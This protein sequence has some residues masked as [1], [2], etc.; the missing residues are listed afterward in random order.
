MVD[1]LPE[2]SL[3]LDRPA[4]VLSRRVQAPTVPFSSF[5]EDD[6]IAR[7]PAV[8]PTSLRP[9]KRGAPEFG[10]LSVASLIRTAPAGGRGLRWPGHPSI[11]PS[12]LT[13]LSD[14][15]LT[16]ALLLR[17]TR[18]RPRVATRL[19]RWTISTSVATVATP[20]D[21]ELWKSS[22]SAATRASRPVAAP[23]RERQPAALASRRG[24]GREQAL[25]RLLQPRQSGTV[26][27]SRRGFDGP[28]PGDARL[29]RVARPTVRSRPCLPL[30]PRRGCW[31][32]R[33]HR[34]QR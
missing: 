12:S 34:H 1:R 23:P 31:R 11:A 28:P 7:R 30:A 20:A 22:I 19:L 5:R 4:A 33:S 15:E 32:F 25:R 21:R 18:A 9:P 3:T 16:A 29:W 24:A 17:R 14:D 27:R 2:R 10:P 6:S 8:S 26:G 13:R